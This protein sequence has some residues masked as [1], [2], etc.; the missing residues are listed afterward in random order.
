MAVPE[1]QG[2]DDAS[3]PGAEHEG[4]KHL[5]PLN[6]RN[7]DPEEILCESVGIFPRHRPTGEGERER[8]RETNCAHCQR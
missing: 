7:A 8:E 6:D 1:P 5:A 3:D 4:V 2:E